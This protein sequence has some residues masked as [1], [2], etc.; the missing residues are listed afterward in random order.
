[1]FDDI[2]S[3]IKARITAIG[4]ALVA[5]LM[6]FGINVSPEEQ[7]T[8]VGFL[9]NVVDTGAAAIASILL[10]YAAFKEFIE[11]LTSP[12]PEPGAPGS[13]AK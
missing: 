5:L 2:T 1:M 8:L 9:L 13:E 3:G 7:A 10:A 12:D 11:K 4:M 6:V